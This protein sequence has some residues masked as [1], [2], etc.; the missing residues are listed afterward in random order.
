MANPFHTVGH[1]KLSVAEFVGLLTS[2][3]A[4]FVVDVRAFP[5]SR[6]N[7]QFNVD[8]FPPALAASG[9]GYEH[10][11][12]LGGRRPRQP[13]VPPERNAF[14]SNA[15]FHN[16]AD[17]AESAAFAGGFARLL[18]LGR[19]R[20]CAI[21]CAEAV[22]W[23]CHRRI[24]ADYLIAGG[25]RVLH[26]MPDGRTAPARLTPGARTGP[27]GTLAYPPTSLDMTFG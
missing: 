13:D 3:G 15:S 17:Y 18:E 27:D 23:R 10:L 2:A 24:I 4:D 7:P 21:M 14:W 20:S 11:P 26:I 16:Y 25:E 12:E 9:I 22:W 6:T 1:A 5:R 8:T 19:R